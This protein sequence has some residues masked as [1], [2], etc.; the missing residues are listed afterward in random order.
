MSTRLLTTDR[1]LHDLEG[2]VEHSRGAVVKVHKEA[3]RHLL[4]DHVTLNTELMRKHGAL[5]E[6]EP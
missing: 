2:I 4:H 1:E 6:T 5:P 3:L